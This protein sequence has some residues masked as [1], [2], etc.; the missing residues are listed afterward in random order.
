MVEYK[1]NETHNQGPVV[2]CQWETHF[3]SKDTQ[4]KNERMENDIPSKWNTKII[5]NRLPIS[6]KIDFKT[7]T[8]TG[9]K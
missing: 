5:R 8:V 6:D 3:L 1:T 7:K 9:D 4:I 2:C